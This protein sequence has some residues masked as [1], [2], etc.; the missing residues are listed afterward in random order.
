MTLFAD[1]TMVQLLRGT[2]AERVLHIMLEGEV[3]IEDDGLGAPTGKVF[4]GDNATLGGV[5]MVRIVG[6]AFSCMSTFSAA[7]LATFT[8]NINQGRANPQFVMLN[9]DEENTD[10]GRQCWTFWG[11]EKADGTIVTS[12]YLSVE[13][14]G[15][16]DD[17]KG[18]VDWYVNDG[19]EGQFPTTRPLRMTSTLITF[20]VETVGPVGRVA[21]VWNAVAGGFLHTASEADRVTDFDA[22][23]ALDTGFSLT[24]GV[25][26]TAFAARVKASF[27]IDSEISAGT[28]CNSFWKLQH[29]PAAGS[30]ADVDAA[31]ARAYHRTTT[32]AGT[33]CI[34]PAVVDVGVGDQLRVLGDVEQSTAV[35][36]PIKGAKLFVERIS[37]AS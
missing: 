24:G 26:E 12:A 29:K 28:R 22:S 32:N 23:G 36:I 10:G 13:H 31:F 1:R 3:W 9:T 37:P 25:L 34:A 35:I 15:T 14:E 16:S 30:W 7:G 19:T 27:H 17:D 21:E 11:G 5:E 20:G 2:A 6:S 8:G 33:A 4:V 18:R